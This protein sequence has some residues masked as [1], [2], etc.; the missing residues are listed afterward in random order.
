M[1]K[2]GPCSAFI[3][4]GCF[5]RESIRWVQKWEPV[6]RHLFPSWREIAA[7]KGLARVAVVV[8]RVHLQ[9]G[10]RVPARAS[11]FPSPMLSG[12]AQ[13]CALFLGAPILTG[14]HLAWQATSAF[15]L[16]TK[17]LEARFWE[18]LRNGGGRWG[19]LGAEIPP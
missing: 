13:V 11:G 10:G 14:L 16:E 17:E 8:G 19:C 9:Y 7:V 2:G 1:S 5:L 18:G 15:S 12:R 6:M 4:T 3:S